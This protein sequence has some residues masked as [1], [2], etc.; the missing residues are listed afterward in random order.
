MGA[1]AHDRADSVLHLATA[2]IVSKYHQYLVISAGQITLHALLACHSFFCELGIAR[3]QL[4]PSNPRGHDKEGSERETDVRRGGS[5]RVVRPRPHT[6][7]T[8]AT[9]HHPCWLLAVAACM[10]PGSCRP[11]PP[12]ARDPSLSGENE[13]DVEP[14]RGR[15]ERSHRIDQQA[16]AH[17]PAPALDAARS[18][19]GGGG[20]TTGTR[21]MH[22]PEPEPDPAEASHRA[23]S[24]AR[25]RRPRFNCIGCACC[26]S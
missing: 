19:Q 20:S 23:L 2:L 1:I 6:D 21:H 25:T 7:D 24:L 8:G 16:C 11:G 13:V 10:F 3:L 5:A 22:P 12:R 26:F 17:E 9:H 4:G 15:A 14:S 18:L